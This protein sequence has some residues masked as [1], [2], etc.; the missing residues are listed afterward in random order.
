MSTILAALPHRYG[1]GIKELEALVVKLV[2]K[3]QS[4]GGNSSIGK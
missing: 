1:Q 2:N 3:V 4:P